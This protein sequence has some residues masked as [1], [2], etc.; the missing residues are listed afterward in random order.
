MNNRGFTLVELVVVIAIIA[1]MAGIFTVNMTNMLQTVKSDEEK[2]LQSDFELAADAYINSNKTELAK[3]DY[4]D[5][6][7][8]ISKNILLST[9]FLKE[10][11]Q[12]NYPDV[13]YVCKDTND[14]LVF[15]LEV[16]DNE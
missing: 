9:G 4:C 2:R 5:S 1:A 11:S 16:V 8:A 3:I 13:I 12:N 7:Y 10:T 15:S 6:N 14:V